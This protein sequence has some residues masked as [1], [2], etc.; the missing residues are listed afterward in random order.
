MELKAAFNALR[1][2]AKDLLGSNILLRV[3]NTTALAYINKFGSIQHPH[4][5]AISRQIWRWCEERDIFIF[6]SYIASINNCIAD[7]ESRVLDPNTEWS[8]SEK[9]FRQV[10][11]CFGPFDIDLFASAINKKC[12][13]YFSWFPDPGSIAI[14]VFTISWKELNFYAF[15]PFIMLP[16]VLRKIVDE[17]AVGTLVVPWWPS[18]AWFPL[19]QRLLVSEP[20]IFS[21][22]SSLLSSPFRNQHPEYRTLSLGDYR[23]GFQG[24]TGSSLSNSNNASLS[25]RGYYK[26]ILTS[27][28]KLV[29][30]L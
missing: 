5:S 11:D 13:A 25:I 30:F 4:L 1:C 18:Q 28:P 24:P 16:R 20:I 21:P 12:Q 8:L 6:A 22:S 10:V 23:G 27:P 14:D 26:A 29:D 17:G 7:A 2:F 3:D 19:F 15:P 9:V